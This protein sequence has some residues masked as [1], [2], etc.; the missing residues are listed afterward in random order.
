MRQERMHR[1]FRMALDAPQFGKGVQTAVMSGDPGQD[2]S[3]RHADQVSRSAVVPAHV[4]VISGDFGAGMG[5]QIDKAKGQRLPPGS[6]VHM[7][8]GRP[9]SHGPIALRSCR[10]RVWGR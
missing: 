3:V 5:E 9:I 2:R 1:Q 6:F 4:T 10:S 8:A 7:P